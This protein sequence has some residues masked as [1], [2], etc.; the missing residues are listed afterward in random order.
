MGLIFFRGLAWQYT[1]ETIAIVAVEVVVAW[2][3]QKEVMT[4]GRAAIILSL[5]PLSLVLVGTLEHF[6]LD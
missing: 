4:M 5:F 1:A 6:G 2:M 3:V